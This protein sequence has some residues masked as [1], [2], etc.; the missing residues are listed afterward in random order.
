M[1]ESAGGQWIPGEDDEDRGKPPD[2]VMDLLEEQGKEGII[3]NGVLAWILAN[4]ENGAFGIWKQIAEHH[5]GDKEVFEARNLLIKV[6]PSLAEK[7]PKMDK[8]RR[9][10]GHA[11]DDINSSI[12]YMKEK[13]L[14][15]P[16]VLATSEQWRSSPQCMGSVKPQASMGDMASKVHKLEEIMGEFMAT[17]SKKMEILT[18]LVKSNVN[19]VVKKPE[20]VKRKHTEEPIILDEGTGEIQE[21]SYAAIASTGSQDTRRTMTQNQEESVALKNLLQKITIQNPEKKNLRQR[22]KDIFH[23]KAKA[24]EEETGAENLAAD[25]D[26]VAFGVST[27]TEPDQLKAFLIGKGREIENVECM[28]RPELL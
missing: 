13:G 10:K 24:V 14:M 18:E 25:V 16:L 11:L 21:T 20:E 5:Y 17:S 4:R 26:L 27:K 19:E 2:S 8:K 12:T 1:A 6:T 7:I 22:N 9:N 3:V 15:A 23:G 28:T